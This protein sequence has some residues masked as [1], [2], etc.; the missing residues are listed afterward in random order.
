MSNLTQHL[1][2]QGVEQ[3]KHKADI[4]IATRMLTDGELSLEQIVKYTELELVEIQE[5]AS[6][7]P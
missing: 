3:G 4:E 1:F 6:R 5:L 7:L 2:E